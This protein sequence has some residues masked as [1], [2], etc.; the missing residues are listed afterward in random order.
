MPTIPGRLR[1][2]GHEFKAI[3]NYISSSSH[4]SKIEKK[5]DLFIYVHNILGTVK[6]EKYR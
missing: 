3:M 2:K 4:V 6:M 5:L 1:L